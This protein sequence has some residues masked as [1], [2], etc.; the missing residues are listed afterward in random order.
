MNTVYVQPLVKLT[1]EYYLH[2]K[3]TRVKSSVKVLTYTWNH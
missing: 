2:L 1:E 3:F